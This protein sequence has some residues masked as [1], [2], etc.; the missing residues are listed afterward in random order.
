ML[1]E[2][3]S[4]ADKGVL[5]KK[6]IKFLLFPL[7]WSGEVKKQIKLINVNKDQVSTLSLQMMSQNAERL[8]K[9]GRKARLLFY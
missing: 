4:V 2:S 1:L 8:G 7:T 5:I 6:L 9:I 3:V